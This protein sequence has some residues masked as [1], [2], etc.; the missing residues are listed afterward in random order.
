M[1][2]H[3]PQNAAAGAPG[4]ALL[5]DI[6]ITDSRSWLDVQPLLGGRAIFLETGKAVWPLRLSSRRGVSRLES[7]GFE[8]RSFAGPLLPGGAAPEA[9]RLEELPE[10]V[11]LVDL[12]RLPVE[13][14]DLFCREA[15][16]RV[17]R[18]D[19]QCFNLK[20]PRSFETL[21]ASLKKNFRANLRKREAKLRKASSIEYADV[22]VT[23]SSLADALALCREISEKSWQGTSKVSVTVSDR[24]IALL[25]DLTRTDI[26]QRL[27]ILK[28][29]G[30]PAAVKWVFERGGRV[31]F[32]FS[33]YLPRFG[34]YGVAN[35]LTAHAMRHYIDR[36]VFEVDFGYGAS[37]QK[38]DWG[39]SPRKLARLIIPLTP[40]GLALCSYQRLRWFAGE[41]RTRLKALPRPSMPHI[42][43][44]SSKSARVGSDGHDA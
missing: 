22:A 15:P 9:V 42:P 32:H 2:D 14:G 39:A 29:D 11:D 5:D 38:Y 18:E 21:H 12:R 33:E 34:Q 10:T 31:L 27:F 23:E 17:F 3:A 8:T 40:R 44:F 43:R 19:G 37:N 4:T 26:R 24:K 30:A 36:G 16:R 35:L 20:L 41:A 28:A 7:L 13:F 25:S 1:P 6:P